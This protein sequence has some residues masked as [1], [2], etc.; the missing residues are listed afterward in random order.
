[1]NSWKYHA[2][3][4]SVLMVVSLA[5]GVWADW[6]RKRQEKRL[7]SKGYRLCECGSQWIEPAPRGGK[8]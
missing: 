8:P 1:M 5:V 7:K 3:N 6:M 4:I 2:V